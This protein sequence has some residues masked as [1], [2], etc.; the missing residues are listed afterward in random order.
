M[1]ILSIGRDSGCDIVLHDHSDVISRRHAVLN[2]TSTGK[3]TLIDQGRNGTYVNGIKITPNIP[4]PVKRNDVVSFAH[5]MQLDWTLI[6]NYAAR[7]YGIIGAA[8]A[9]LLL[10]GGAVA[11]FILRG[12]DGS[13]SDR[14]DTM[15]VDSVQI[16]R[17]D[18]IKVQSPDS[19]Q[20]QKTD[21]SRDKSVSP[22]VI[23]KLPKKDNE[24]GDKAPKNNS[25]EQEPDKPATPLL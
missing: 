25:V 3:M 12:G 6:P 2:I 22:K 15:V 23:K 19:T 1:K 9:V 5:V 7:F 10:I 16:Q 17:P 21:K 4:F 24:K 20:K 18:S 13:G 11:F 8:F 14:G